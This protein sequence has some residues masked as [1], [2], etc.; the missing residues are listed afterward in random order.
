MKNGSGHPFDTRFATGPDFG[1]KL[2][3]LQGR[4]AARTTVFGKRITLEYAKYA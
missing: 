2:T 4:V 3:F 1:R